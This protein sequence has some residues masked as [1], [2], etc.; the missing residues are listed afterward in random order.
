MTATSEND[1]NDFVV[2]I[3]HGATEAAKLG[4]LV[5]WTLYKQPLDYPHGYLAR[6]WLVGGGHR[7]PISTQEAFGTK[8]VGEADL[9]RLREMFY[10]AGMT[11]LP[12]NAGDEP[13]IMGCWL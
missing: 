5:M 7:D 4:Y 9:E 11:F 13:Q 12:R 8:D 2:R 3:S 1:L 6:K 10:R